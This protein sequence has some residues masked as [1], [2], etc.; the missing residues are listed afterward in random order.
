MNYS[1]TD[2]PDS[3]NKPI[4]YM[5]I[6]L[7]NEVIGRLQ[8]RLFRDVFP[9]GVENFIGLAEGR[10]YKVVK[11]GNGKYKFNKETKRTYDGCKFYHFMHN[12]YIV[13]GDIYNN[14][15]SSAGSVYNDTPIPPL[16]GEYFYPHET[17][18][19]ISLV[20]FRDEATGK[21]FYDS[22][23]MITLD[24]K[25]PTNV[26]NELDDNQIVIGEVY[27]GLD[28]LTKMNELI[29]PFARRKYPEFIISKCGSHL[30]SN[31]RRYVNKQTIPPKEL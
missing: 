29:K 21:I 16:F 26:I 19:L 3:G 20:P 24:D 28:V 9:A 13:C 30:P 14:N 27:D 6:S 25:K 5:D 23:F 1:L 15:G 7:K 4:V 2:I 11:N 10:T 17:K 18:G 22:T 31:R 8:I 12:N